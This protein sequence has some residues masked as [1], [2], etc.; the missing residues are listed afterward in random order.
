MNITQRNI[1]SIGDG[2]YWISP[3]LYLRVRNNGKS[4]KFIVKYT[5]NKKRKEISLGGPD[6]KT[7]QEAKDQSIRILRMVID[8]ED[9]KLILDQKKNIINGPSLKVYTLGIWEEYVTIKNFRNP[10]TVKVHLGY[11]NRYIFPYFKEKPLASIT[12]ADVAEFGQYLLER[13]PRSANNCLGVLR[14]IFK[15]AIRDGVY[16]GINPASWD[17]A[18]DAYLPRYAKMGKENHFKSMNLSDLRNSLLKAIVINR[19]SALCIAMIALTA[20]RRS[21][22][23]LLHWEELDFVKNVINIPSERRKDGKNE[24][25]RVP[26]TI[27]IKMILDYLSEDEKLEFVFNGRRKRCFTGTYISFEAHKMFESKGTIHGM[28]STFRDWAAEEGIDAMLAESCLMHSVG[29]SVYKAYQR[30]DLLDQRRDVMQRYA[31]KLLPV[32][33]LRKALSARATLRDRLITVSEEKRE[34]VINA[35]E[36][37]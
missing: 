29:T 35:S 33:Q 6:I 17:G 24:I 25:F 13:I 1:N 4:R 22:I 23:R 27:Q 34:D 18:L 21:E 16:K 3:K 5:F 12:V 9:P 19:S 32:D 2:C 28:R 20:C 31:D 8:G 14:A 7:I 11:L 26:I 36:I 37:L 15:F 10:D 30:S